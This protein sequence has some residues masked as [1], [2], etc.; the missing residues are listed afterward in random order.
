MQELEYN[1]G[2]FQEYDYEQEYKECAWRQ[3]DNVLLDKYYY[4][5]Q[6]G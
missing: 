2:N 1:A 4:A 5:P 6:K 3:D